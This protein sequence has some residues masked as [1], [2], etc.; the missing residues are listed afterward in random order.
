MEYYSVLKR[1]ELS[2]HEKT[3]RKLKFLLPSERSQSEKATIGFQLDGILERAKQWR[4]EK[5]TGCYEFG[6]RAG[7]M[8]RIFSG[9]ETIHMIL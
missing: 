7:G 6:G 2:S 3:W 1:N 8:N 4:C 9:S 5:V